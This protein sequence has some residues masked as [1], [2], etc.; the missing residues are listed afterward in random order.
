M[1]KLHNSNFWKEKY[2]L[3][4]RALASHER[5]T[6]LG[7]DGQLFDPFLKSLEHI[8]LVLEKGAKGI[9]L[10]RL[11]DL[12]NPR[13][14]HG[15]AHATLAAR[16]SV[17]QTLGFVLKNEL[18]RRRLRAHKELLD[19]RFLFLDVLDN[20]ADVFASHLTRPL[21]SLF[22]EV[23]LQSHFRK[24]ILFGNLVKLATALEAVAQLDLLR[25][26]ADI[27]ANL[28]KD[29]LKEDLAKGTG[30]AFLAVLLLLLL[31]VFGRHGSEGFFKDARLDGAVLGRHNQTNLRRHG[32]QALG[33]TKLLHL[34]QLVL[35]LGKG[36]VLVGLDEVHQTFLG[37]G[38][39][40]TNGLG[41]LLD[42]ALE[43]ALLQ[44]EVALVLDG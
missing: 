11:E 23:P 2:N 1:K 30:C 8:S 20:F 44:N 37:L 26:V 10:K 40:V 6:H 31:N 17:H 33:R 28:G 27:L 36:L 41:L 32:R 25:D 5:N 7:L 14:H 29:C 19:E 34:L 12:G 3:V 18:L 22:I 39:L 13:A 42:R 38:N 21:E 24:A 4:L 43:R 9:N 35:G 15:K 16:G